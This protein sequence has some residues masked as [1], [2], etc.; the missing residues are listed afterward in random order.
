MRAFRMTKP[1]LAKKS[2]V[3][4]RMISYILSKKKTPT[5]ETAEQIAKPFGLTSWQL[6]I[7]NITA[8]LAKAG[9][10]ERLVKN[11]LASSGE[12]QELITHVAEREVQYK[13]KI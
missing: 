5:V 1:Q 13:K 2:G 4:E 3:S 11:Y 12:G 9:A 7:P 8:S 10:L 6:I